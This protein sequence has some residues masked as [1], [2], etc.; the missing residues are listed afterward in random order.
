M[1]DLETVK[2]KMSK[3]VESLESNL[4]TIRTGVANAAL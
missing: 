1:M 3:A 4:K 2:S